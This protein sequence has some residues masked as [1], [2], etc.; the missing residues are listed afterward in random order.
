MQ[1]DSVARIPAEVRDLSIYPLYGN[2]HARQSY[3]V[4]P[5]DPFLIFTS[6]G[7]SFKGE[8]YVAR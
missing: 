7:E 1:R 8:S 3:T 2:R 6:E 4:A 5:V